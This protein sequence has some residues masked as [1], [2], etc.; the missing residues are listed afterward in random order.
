LIIQA[1]K[2]IQGASMVKRH[3]ILQVVFTQPKKSLQISFLFFHIFIVA[4]MDNHLR[5]VIVFARLQSPSNM[6][7]DIPIVGHFNGDLKL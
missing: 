2:I 5:L 7:Y 3:K 6:S 1:Q 4:Y